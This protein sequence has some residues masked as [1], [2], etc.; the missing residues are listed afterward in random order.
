[1]WFFNHSLM[2][3]T[4]SF[5]GVVAR[6]M[7]NDKTEPNAIK[8]HFY[9]FSAYIHVSNIGN[10]W[11]L[12]HRNFRDD[13]IKALALRAINLVCKSI[14]LKRYKSHTQSPFPVTFTQRLQMRINLQ[15]DVTRS[16]TLSLLK[17][18]ADCDLK[19]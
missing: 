7:R 18:S 9:H 12:S 5:C 13:K 17:N 1:M 11:T 8:A 2:E 15:H 3:R 14:T 16:Y 4:F 10:L 6:A 19:T